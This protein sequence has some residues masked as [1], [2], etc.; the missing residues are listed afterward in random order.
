MIAL[1]DMLTYA[2][3]KKLHIVVILHYGFI[4]RRNITSGPI[5]KFIAKTD[6]FKTILKHLIIKTN[7]F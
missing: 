4:I 1:T 2:L 5:G 3:M 6:F 7:E